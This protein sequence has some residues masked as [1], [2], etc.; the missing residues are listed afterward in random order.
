MTDEFSSRNSLWAVLL[1][2]IQW[3]TFQSLAIRKIRNLTSGQRYLDLI[4]SGCISL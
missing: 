4:L 2:W 1:G 3:F